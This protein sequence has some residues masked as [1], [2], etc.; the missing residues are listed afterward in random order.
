MIDF[1]RS[2]P[3]TTEGEAC[4]PTRSIRETLTRGTALASRLPEEIT[5]TGARL[6]VVAVIYLRCE[7]P[8]FGRQERAG[9][10]GVPVR[11]A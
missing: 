10:H 1:G 5:R 2:K 8:L 7:H 4:A 9:V 11:T 6:H 3:G